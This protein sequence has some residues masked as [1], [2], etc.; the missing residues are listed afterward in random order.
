MFMP[1]PSDV[2]NG[3]PGS[4][5]PYS[6]QPS[7]LAQKV[8]NLFKSA[9]TP[10]P[11]ANTP[12]PADPAADPYD[13][14]TLTD[15]FLLE[16]FQELKRDAS[17][18]RFVFERQWWRT[19]LYLLNRQW[20]YFDAKRNEWRDKR[21]KKWIPKPVTNKLKEVQ[22]T[23][24]AMF[25]AVQLGTLSRPNGNDPKNISTANTVDQLQPL[26][27]EEHQMESVMPLAD[28]WFVNLGNVFL[29]PWWNPD[30]GT[31][32]PINEDQCVQCGPGSQTVP[33]NPQQPFQCP[34][35][36][37]TQATQVHV[38][39]V[40][41]GAGATDVCSP[42]EML[43][44]SHA[45]VFDEVTK[46]IRVRWRIKSYYEDHYP[47]LAKTLT[48]EQQPQE[49]TLNMFK[50]IASQND[51][52]TTPYTLGTGNRTQ[53]LGLTEYEYWEKP[54]S[55]FPR[56]LF[57]RVAGE[58][59]I[60]HDENQSMP[61]PIPT[62]TAKGQTLWPWVHLAYEIFG[63]KLWSDGCHGPLFQKQDQINQLDSHTQLA[64]QRMGN[65]VW[66]EPKGTEVERFTGE[67]G[68]VVKYATIG[69][70]AVKPERIPG[71]D[72]KP[73][74]F[75]LRQQYLQDIEELAGTYDILKGHKP[76]GVE[77]F[78]ALQL[79]VER[80]Q[81]RFTA[82]FQARGEAYRKWFS[83]ALELERK[84]GPQQRTMSLLGPNGTWTFQ[85]F[86]N[87][88]LLGDISIV[89]EDGTNVPKTAL[90]RR[91][92]LEQVFNMGAINPADPDVKYA[93]LSEMGLSAYMPSLD[94]AKNAALRQQAAFEQ[95]AKAG[96]QGMPPL[97][98]QPWDDPEILL[99]E[100]RKWA[101]S[102]VMQ[103]ILN[104]PQVGQMC[105][106]YV[107]QYYEQLATMIQMAQAAQAQNAAA[108]GAIKTAHPFAPGEPVAAGGGHA[109]QPGHGAGGAQAM[110][111]SNVNSTKASIATHGQSAA[112]NPAAT[113]HA[114]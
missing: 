71:E 25:A 93:L 41:S 40:P 12:P 97:K 52:A 83:I 112:G 62:E 9:Q 26:I 68:L 28:F 105:T 35:C 55:Q 91:A 111:R 78:S 100:L 43:V 81:S 70:T 108:T 102:D 104:D 14:S 65:P 4:G 2:T 79:L 33:I 74:V 18:M 85:T 82:A 98:I 76:T 114:A 38:T 58:N 3:T 96:A 57:F 13:P 87:A 84:Y 75:A 64:F 50:A 20:I 77:A 1:P 27:H 92:A 23:M 47:E 39:D 69:N 8:A 11:D 37:G 42:F 60:I 73:G 80:S 34:T 54:S 44:P 101:N 103:S 106:Q 31:I 86:Q 61:G 56:G 48:F 113:T 19:I 51:M 30:G 24:R 7:G 90:G 21:L 67:P 99:S 88:D 66:L 22:S 29:H 5:D 109:P 59:T 95:W 17:E 53:T 63:G 6:G 45:S 36:G 32:V 15:T 16:R 94:T 107:V 46:L 110:Q 89:V 72:I 10:P 49:R